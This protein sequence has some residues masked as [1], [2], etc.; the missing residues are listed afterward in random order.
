M[1]SRLFPS[2]AA[3]GLSLSSF[4]LLFAACAGS[5]FNSGVGTS[6]PKHAPYY[7]GA[8]VAGGGARIAHLP[9][10]Y[11]RGA[12]QP[13]IFEPSGGSGTAVGALLAEMNAY[14]DSLGATVRV[15]AAG[16]PP[17][18]APDV[19][20]GCETDASGEC[21]DAQGSVNEGDQR[22]LTL[23]VARPSPEWVAWTASALDGAQATSA[24]VLTLEVAQHWPRQKN[25]RG[26]KEMELGSGY[27]VS[28]P[29]LTSLDKPISV[30]QLTGALMGH[31][32]KAIRIGAEGLLARRTSL[33]LSAAGVQALISDDEVQQVRTLRRTDLAGQPLVWQV[34]LRNL[35]AELTGRSDLALR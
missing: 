33:M 19:Q 34:A 10:S 15:T 30:L 17:G 21:V 25:F 29:W 11:Q 24:L 22:L 26:D 14:L 32:G 1:H 13:A 7:A 28:L 18:A 4:A 31:D 9:I 8:S 12:T 6:F 23:A 2:A 20:F 35:V 27:T 16:T 3:R 5:T